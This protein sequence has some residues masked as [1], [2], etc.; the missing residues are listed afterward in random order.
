MDMVMLC[1]SHAVDSCFYKPVGPAGLR[2]HFTRAGE[3]HLTKAPDTV[4]GVHRDWGSCL[5]FH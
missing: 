5:M 3:K 1:F 4:D 2:P